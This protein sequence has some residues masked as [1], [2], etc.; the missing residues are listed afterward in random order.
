MTSTFY[1][2]TN[3]QNSSVKSKD[4]NSEWIYKLS[5]N[6]QLP[7]GTEIGVADTFIH[8]QGI[9]GAT[10]EIKED[11]NETIY[12]SVYLSDNPHF[13]PKNSF[14]GEDSR[15]ESAMTKNRAFVPSFTPFGLLS[16]NPSYNPDNFNPS[17]GSTKSGFET[18]PDFVE[19]EVGEVIN[20][21][22]VGIHSANATNY[23]NEP[24]LQ[25]RIALFEDD[26]NGRPRMSKGQYNTINDP[27]YFGYTEYPMMA[28]Y[29]SNSASYTDNIGDTAQTPMGFDAS[30]TPPPD[31]NQNSQHKSKFPYSPLI[32]DHRFKPYVKSVDIFIRAGVY[33]IAEISDLVENQINGKYVNLKKDDDYYNDTISTKQGNQ[34]YT[35]TLET[36]GIYTKVRPLDRQGGSE[37]LKADETN[38][39]G[40]PTV[41]LKQVC[42]MSAY[43]GNQ[44]SS[45]NESVYMYQD[46]NPTGKA[47]VGT[48]FNDRYSIPYVRDNITQSINYF[49]SSGVVET[50]DNIPTYLLPYNDIPN[51]SRTYPPNDLNDF[52]LIG[53]VKGRKP[54]LPDEDQLFYIPVH[55]YN[56]L[57]K[58]WKFSDTGGNSA[59]SNSYL[60]ETGNWTDN[61][62]RMFR[63]MF[64]QKLNLYGDSVSSNNGNETA[65]DDTNRFNAPFIGL[66]TKVKTNAR[67]DHFQTVEDWAT[68]PVFGSPNDSDCNI[69]K[70][71][72]TG[73]SQSQYN[74]DI[75]SQG[76]YVGTPDFEF[77]YDNDMSAFT[78]QGLHQ[79]LRMPSCDASGNPVN[80]E[81]QTGLFL[82]RPSKQLAKDLVEP[83]RT[84]DYLRTTPADNNFDARFQKSGGLDGFK[85]KITNTLNQNESRVGGVA[86]YNWAYQTALKYGDIDPITHRKPFD[87]DNPNSD[88]YKVYDSDF[89]HLWK[90][91]D[92][93]SSD[94]KMRE[95]WEK[96]L[97]FR[98]GFTFDNLQN[99]NTW[100]KC[101]YYDLPIDK[102][103][104]VGTPNKVE[105]Q[106][107][108]YYDPKYKMYFKNE[109]FKLYGKTT[110][111]ELG[112]DSVP[113]ISSVFNNSLFK[114]TPNPASKESSAGDMNQIIRTYDN[115][116]ISQPLFVLQDKIDVSTYND[117]SVKFAIFND[118][119]TDTMRTT[120][121]SYENSTYWCKIRVPLLT[122]SKNIV[123][124]K[125]PQ[126]SEQGYY[127]ITSDII[128]GYEDEVKEG[129]PIP[130]LGIV[131]ISN[132]SNQDFI[133]TKND[134]VHILQ[135]AKNLNKIKIKV[136]NPDLTA[137][138]LLENSSVILRITTPLP[139]NTNQ[140][141]NQQED[142]EQK[143]ERTKANLN[144]KDNKTI[145]GR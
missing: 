40:I 34:T 126:L 77:S 141:G 95:A 78:I 23:F 37:G 119:T 118:T 8:K 94:E 109:D 144:P 68:T 105:T 48:P 108:F 50:A 53:T 44:Q 134:I 21:I 6:L 3:R 85:T 67:T 113:T 17:I 61:T 35:G 1:I 96:T 111:A 131:P 60:Y 139:Q 2:D 123:A 137:P 122:E 58:M 22:K 4:N 52:N 70:K 83:R 129:T 16:N 25:Q 115:S 110:N 41:R 107:N 38:A 33:S 65:N 18:T 100:E 128:D 102:Y 124:T 116:D 79:S 75:F 64:Q 97:W 76:Y 88:T 140:I 36:D 9:S 89:T 103:S 84:I 51:N 49:N 125:L 121:Y 63:Y 26:G 90:F 30:I 46:I 132:L 117:N 31:T 11:I 42:S 57:I 19:R 56:Q 15:T 20:N 66:H 143:N 7:A 130:M 39:D 101:P 99:D 10:I 32:A 54:V 74:Y 80:S 12:F 73:C 91:Q 14:A 98:L 104:N 47:M 27:Y 13:V 81:G 138:S 24:S 69:E 93:F 5:N 114:Y 87:P 145:S 112:V 92:F 59:T 106:P 71:T 72:H 142:G 62:K 29:V 127:I 120:K 133:T 136:L 43:N 82:K 86:I 45:F 28:I 135:Q 55:L